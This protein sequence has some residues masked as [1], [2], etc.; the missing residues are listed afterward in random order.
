MVIGQHF[1]KYVDPHP[2][3]KVILSVM[4]V[5]LPAATQLFLSYKQSFLF[6]WHRS[7]PTELCVPPPTP[8]EMLLKEILQENGSK[9]K[10]SPRQTEGIHGTEH[11]SREQRHCG[12]ESTQQKKR[13]RNNAVYGQC[14]T[15]TLKLRIKTVLVENP[16]TVVLF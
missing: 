6:L 11:Y 15:N 13:H 1:P 7:F 4:L 5:R 8:W 16:P 14:I 3:P 9:A 10:Y 2:A 12:G